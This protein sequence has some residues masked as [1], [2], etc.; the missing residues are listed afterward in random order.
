MLTHKQDF[1]YQ[2]QSGE[3]KYHGSPSEYVAFR[4]NYLA[5]TKQVFGQNLSNTEQFQ[6]N[7]SFRAAF[8]NFK[9]V[10]DDPQHN[11]FYMDPVDSRSALIRLEVKST[12]N[13]MGRL[14]ADGSQD[15]A[16]F[17]KFLTALKTKLNSA[18]VS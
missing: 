9:T 3:A 17:E 5:P 8:K 7:N 18:S 15:Q 14:V 16:S 4:G 2:G 10:N 13:Q 6:Q 12:L 11:S 1:T